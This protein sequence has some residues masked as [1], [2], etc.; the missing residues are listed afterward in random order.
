MVAGNS[1]VIGLA[2]NVPFSAVMS[3][4]THSGKP[5]SF[6]GYGST[7]DAQLRFCWPA[8]STTSPGRT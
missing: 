5:R 1:S 7:F 2:L 3:I 8:T 6:G 4:S